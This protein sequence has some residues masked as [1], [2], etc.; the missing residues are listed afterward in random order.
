M[1]YRTGK[2]RRP[3]LNCLHERFITLK[4]DIE[5]GEEETRYLPIVLPML[6]GSITLGQ[7]EIGIGIGVGVGV[8]LPGI[9][10]GINIPSHPQL[11]R[12]SGYPVYDVLE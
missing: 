11:V 2:I 8:P 7:A 4:P 9:S 10:I 6:P 5:T 12:V 3:R 1:L